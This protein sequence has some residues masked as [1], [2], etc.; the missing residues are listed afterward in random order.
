[1]EIFFSYVFEDEVIAKVE[2]DFLKL[3]F[4]PVMWSMA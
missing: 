4:V 1:M 3:H 2:L